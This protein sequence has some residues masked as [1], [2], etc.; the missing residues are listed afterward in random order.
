MSARCIP[1]SMEVSYW[2]AIQGPCIERKLSD[3]RK[4]DQEDIFIHKGVFLTSKRFSFTLPGGE[5]VQ[6]LRVSRERGS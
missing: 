2:T 3:P 6:I 4:E 5:F 1:K